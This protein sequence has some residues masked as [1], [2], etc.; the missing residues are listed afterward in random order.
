MKE[1]LNIVIIDDNKIDSFVNRKII[2]LAYPDASVME[3]NS[4]VVALEYFNEKSIKGTCDSITKTDLILLDINMPI[5]SGFDF[6]E[7]LALN[8]EFIKNPIDIYFLSSSNNK[9]DISFAENNPYCM[10]YIIKPLT[11]EKVNKVINTNRTKR[12]AK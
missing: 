8:K 7:R 10:E 1:Q 11:K 9:E 12:F 2:T 3:F 4:S 5:M 6:I